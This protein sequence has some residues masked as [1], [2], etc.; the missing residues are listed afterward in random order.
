M[1]KKAKTTVG[2]SKAQKKSAKG[3]KQ[4]PAQK[5]DIKKQMRGSNAQISKM[6]GVSNG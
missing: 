6:S 4:T 2:V 5:R 3:L 1:A